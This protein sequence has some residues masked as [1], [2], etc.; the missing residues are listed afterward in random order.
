VDASLLAKLV[1]DKTSLALPVER[2]R[3]QLAGLGL[4]VPPKTLASYWAYTLD[5][6]EPVAVATLS[7]VFGDEVVGLDDSHLKT[8]DKSSK[9]GVFRGHLWCFVGTESAR[10]TERV[11]YGY[12]QSWE[13][14]EIADWLGAIDG[15]IQGDGYAGY[16]T[17]LEDEETGETFVLIPDERR[18]G[19]GMHIRSKFHDALL[20]Q[21]KRAA[22]PLKHFADLYEIEAECKQQG[23]D[24]LARAEQRRWRSLPIVDALDHWVDAVHPKLLPKSPLRRATTYAINQRV[25]FRRCFEDGRFEIDNGRVERRIRNFAVGRRNYLF[26]GSA[27]GGERLAAAYTLVDNCTLLGVDPYTYLLDIIRKLEAGWPMRRLS[28]L[29]PWAWAAANQ[30]R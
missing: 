7:A 11:G 27:R 13:A 10:A 12:T 29:I 21:D 24:A 16:S 6:V 2:Q 23:L 4:H 1:A 5:L 26:T 14:I 22:V 15:F 18:L 3:R 8:L 30:A 28:E 9:Q 20:A 19:C 25:F 17:E